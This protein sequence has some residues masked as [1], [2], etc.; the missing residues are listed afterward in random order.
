MLNKQLQDKRTFEEIKLMLSDWGR[1]KARRLAEVATRVERKNDPKLS[2]T[3][4]IAVK[5]APE[6]KNPV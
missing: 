6:S 5:R 3:S 4:Q 1:A 2:L